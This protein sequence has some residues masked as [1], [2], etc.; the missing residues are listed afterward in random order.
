MKK[1]FDVFFPEHI[2]TY[3]STRDNDFTLNNLYEEKIA[4][5]KNELMFS[6]FADVD[7][8][9][10]DHIV[11][12]DKILNRP[13]ADAIITQRKNLA[14]SI[15][16]AD[17]L[18]V[19]IYCK[20]S[21]MI[22]VVHAGWRGTQQKILYKTLLK[23]NENQS[24]DFSSIKIAFGPCLR[25]SNYEVGSEFVD[26]FKSDVELLDGKYYFD[27]IGANMRQLKDLGIKNDQVYD[28]GID[29]FTDDN[30]FSFRK[31]GKL[32][33]RM[34]SIILIRG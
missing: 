31:E 25:K 19:F 13:Q 18:P 21:E 26:Y 3:V 33:G 28:C 29:T 34:I 7:Q 27:L 12:I 4:N 17:C 11:W 1:I 9:H 24:E 30:Y 6:D 5:L 10:G 8:V 15:R 20:K 16:T 23:L 14:I 32:A 2:L 22:A